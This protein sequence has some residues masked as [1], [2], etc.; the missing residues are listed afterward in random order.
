MAKKAK[1]PAA[2]KFIDEITKAITPGKQSMQ[3][4]RERQAKYASGRAHEHPFQSG[5][6]VRLSSKNIKLRSD[7]TA[8]WQPKWLGPFKLIRMVG[9][10]AVELELPNTMKNP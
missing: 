10:Q 6:R 9:T 8:K 7:G 4:A 2:N 1:V 3:Q 5:Q